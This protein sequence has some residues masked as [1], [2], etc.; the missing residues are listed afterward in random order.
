MRDRLQAIAER[1]LQL[2]RKMADPTA[3]SDGA[4]R[5]R[6]G[7]EYAEA[8]RVADLASR[9]EKTL[10]E[11]EDLHA[12]EDEENDPEIAALARAEAAELEAKLNDLESRIELALLPRDA[13]EDADAILEIRAGA[14]GDEAGL[15]AA[16][17]F[18]MYQRYAEDRGWRVHI[19]SV[20]DTGVGGIKEATFEVEGE[21]AYSR[22][23]LE[24]G[25]HRVQRVPATESQGRIHTS[26]AT[27]AVLP[28]A[29]EIDI[30]IK[31]D[32]LRIDIFHAGGHGGQ[33]VNKVATAVRVT[34]I[35]TGIVAQ[36]HRERSQNQNR[37][38]AM[39]VLRAR[40]WDA[41]LRKQQDAIS[42][43]RKAQVGTGDRSEKIRTYNFPQHRVTD[44]RINLTIHNL[45]MVLE[46]NLDEI[47]D[48]L[49]R[50][51]LTRRLA[52]VV[53]RQS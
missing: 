29:E 37:V 1:R 28:K 20:S 17:L 52:G 10:L 21:N 47:I 11:L 26:A 25:V 34:H 16:E 32:D 51:E 33:N 19:I 3:V 50:E 7:R 42:A 8:Q 9:L 41:E 30:A 18:R 43:D 53:E 13:T 45:P 38:L 48:S 44:H 6:I 40:L 2:E 4:S 14:G 12:L 35:P 23:K 36:S 46:G 49:I 22:L 15:F 31:P 5:K 24:S 39:E 27:V